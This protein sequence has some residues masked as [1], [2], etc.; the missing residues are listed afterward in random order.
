MHEGHI[1]HCTICIYHS[2]Q[3][4][5]RYQSIPSNLDLDLYGS[6]RNVRSGKAEAESIYT[7]LDI[8]AEECSIVHHRIGLSTIYLL[9]YI[10][11]IHTVLDTI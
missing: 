2:R 9:Y 11:I 6:S 4:R 7:V 1:H 3:C 10:H 8:L 5:S